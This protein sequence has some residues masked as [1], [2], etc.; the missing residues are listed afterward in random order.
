MCMQEIT[1]NKYNIDWN[2]ASQTVNCVET[3]KRYGMNTW[4]DAR[5]GKTVF[6]SCS[7][8]SLL[9]DFVK[10]TSLGLNYSSLMWDRNS[11]IS[12]L[13]VN[14]CWNI[15]PEVAFFS[16]ENPFLLLSLIKVEYYRNTVVLLQKNTQKINNSFLWVVRM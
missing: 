9:C 2:L 12:S 4:Q 10:I 11:C 6:Q 7:T 1:W 13:N 5:A 16:Q 8:T 14:C 15:N 3:Q